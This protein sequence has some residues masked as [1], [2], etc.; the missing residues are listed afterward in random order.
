MYK[1]EELSLNDLKTINGG[2]KFMK[3]LGFSIGI[4]GAAIEGFFI[5]IGNNAGSVSHGL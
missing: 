4:I 2:D 1:L 3:D 5:N